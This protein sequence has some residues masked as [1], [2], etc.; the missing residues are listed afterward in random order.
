M[1]YD[2][3]TFV[4]GIL[5]LNATAVRV[6]KINLSDQSQ[7]WDM[8]LTT[9][10]SFM[11]SSIK[12][13]DDST[14]VFAAYYE[15]S[16][17]YRNYFL[18]LNYTDGTQ[19]STTNYFINQP[20]AIGTTCIQQIV[21]KVYFAFSATWEVRITAFTVLGEYSKQ[22]RTVSIDSPTFQMDST[23]NI[24]LLAGRYNSKSVW[25]KTTWGKLNQ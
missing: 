20:T 5:Y 15:E 21:D 24:V 3:S 4:T 2:G 19:V 23:G 8:M 1:H 25:M 18:F 17:L 7:A 13:S 10:N 22:Y 14:T 9:T 6:T 12:L 11:E 16:T